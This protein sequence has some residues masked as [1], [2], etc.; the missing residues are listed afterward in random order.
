MPHNLETVK[1]VVPG[2]CSV[3]RENSHPGQGTVIVLGT[4]RGGTSVVAGICHMLGVNMGI[5]ID[6]SNIEDVDFQALITNGY[7]KKVAKKY[8]RRLRSKN[9]IAG[10]KNP[11]IIDHIE[12]IYPLIKQPKFVVVSRDEVATAQREDVEGHDFL[13]ALEE[14]SRMKRAILDFVNSVVDPVI[15]ISYERLLQN[16]YSAILSIASFLGCEAPSDLVQKTSLLVKANS[17]MPNEVDFV[18]ERLAYEKLSKY[19]QIKVAS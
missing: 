16:P 14:A 15:L 13:V 8:F 6:S 9:K 11:R 4:P 18:A 2:P 1:K 17:D 5:S 10:V 3:L 19:R 7:D 12:D